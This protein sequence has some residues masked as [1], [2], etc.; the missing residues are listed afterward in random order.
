MGCKTMCRSIL[1]GALQ[2]MRTAIS[3]LSERDHPLRRALVD[4]LHVRRIPPFAAP[5]NMTQIVMF[6]ADEQANEVR[7]HAETLCARFGVVLPVRGRYF[8]V[9]LGDIHFV[10]ESHA[11]FSTYSFVRPGHVRTPFA[12]S[13]FEGLPLDRVQ[14]LPGQT[15]RATQ[16]VVLDKSAPPPDPASLGAYFD[17]DELVCADVSDGEARIWSNFQVHQDGFGRLLVQDLGLESSADTSRLLQRLQEL[18][19]YRNMALLGLSRAREPMVELS[20]RSQA[21]HD[22]SRV[23]ATLVPT[24]SSFSTFR[25]F[26]RIWRDSQPTR[27]I[28]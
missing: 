12:E 3:L 7:R 19:N 22:A 25:C 1:R 16:V 17:M 13:V 9:Q 4:E 10:W 21:G 24:T 18:G 15:I 14:T 20:A 11:E 28:A 8:S 5:L 23:A 27:D 6:I 26:P 2:A